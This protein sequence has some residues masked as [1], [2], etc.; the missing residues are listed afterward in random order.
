[1]NELSLLLIVDD[2]AI[3]CDERS[4]NLLIVDIFLLLTKFYW[5]LRF[6]SYLFFIFRLFVLVLLSFFPLLTKPQYRKLHCKVKRFTRLLSLDHINSDIVAKGEN[7]TMILSMI[8]RYICC[9]MWQQ[10]QQFISLPAL[11]FFFGKF[12]P[13]IFIFWQTLVCLSIRISSST[14]FPKASKVV[15]LEHL[16]VDVWLYVIMY[17]KGLKQ[18]TFQSSGHIPHSTP[19]ESVCVWSSLY[20]PVLQS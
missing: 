3:S 5:L 15:L 10:W 17:F 12:E 19:L 8:F 4:I 11:A 18:A 9:A 13:I 1:M 6:F 16:F 14:H 2:F 7:N 20:G